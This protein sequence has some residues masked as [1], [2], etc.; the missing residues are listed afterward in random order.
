M[1]MLLWKQRFSRFKAE[2][3]PD[4]AF[5]NKE[6]A[7]TEIF[8]YIEMQYNAIRTHSCLNYLS[9]VKFEQTYYNN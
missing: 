6:D 5:E 9:P 2:L 3:M 7:Q 1:T 4:G 8:A